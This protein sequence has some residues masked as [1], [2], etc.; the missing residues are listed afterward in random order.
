MNISI[1]LS[2]RFYS[3]KDN[4][5]RFDLSTKREINQRKRN[6]RKR[7]GS[8][9]FDNLNSIEE[10]KDCLYDS[11]IFNSAYSISRAQDERSKNNE[12]L[13]HSERIKIRKDDLK[14]SKPLSLADIDKIKESHNASMSKRMSLWIPRTLLAN[15]KQE[16]MISESGNSLAINNLIY[17]CFL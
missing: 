13:L 5:Q 9:A 16:S 7:L 3:S 2:F 12:N 8:D 11:Q 4:V 17:S 6:Q 14:I 10:S 1:K 15:Q